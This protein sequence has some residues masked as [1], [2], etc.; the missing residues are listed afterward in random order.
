MAKCLDSIAPD[1]IILTE[2]QEKTLKGLAPALVSLGFGSGLFSGA[3][4]RQNGL[5]VCGKIPL[6]LR[7]PALAVAAPQRALHV[8]LADTGLALLAVH[9]PGSDDKQFDKAAFW[10]AIVSACGAKD[11]APDIIMGDFNTGLAADFQGEPFSCADRMQALLGM[12]WCDAWREMHG[13]ATEFTWY[14]SKG[15]GFRLDHCFLRRTLAHKLHRAEYS[16]RE[17]EAKLSDHSLLVVD[18]AL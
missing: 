3:S 4:G 14:S 5:F 15:N 18:I 13:E 2:F 17:R 9:I 10:D 1:V 8:N 12:G 7:E 16:H 11:T 6:T